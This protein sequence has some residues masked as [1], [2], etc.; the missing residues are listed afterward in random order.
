[1]LSMEKGKGRA[2]PH[3]GLWFTAATAAAAAAAAADT[4]GEDK[5]GWNKLGAE[6][7]VEEGD[8]W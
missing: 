6:A 5:N 2:T 4:L 8:E 1:M 7:N 3:P